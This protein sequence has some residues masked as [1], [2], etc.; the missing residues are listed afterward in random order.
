[1]QERRKKPTQ[2]TEQTCSWISWAGTPDPVQMA[3]DQSTGHNQATTQI[4]SQT[5]WAAGTRS[6]APRRWERTRSLMVSDNRHPNNNRRGRMRRVL[7]TSSTPPRRH[8]R[9]SNKPNNLTPTTISSAPS[10]TQAHH[11]PRN[12]NKHNNTQPTTRTAS[13]SH[14]ASLVPPRLS[15]YKHDLR[16]PLRPL[17]WGK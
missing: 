15:R 7:W 17:D 4:S 6:P 16:T 9:N 8:H 14:S 13:S 1:M 11:L 3:W 10:A 5:S 12:N 2:I